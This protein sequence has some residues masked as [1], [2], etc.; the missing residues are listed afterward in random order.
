MRQQVC[1][2]GVDPV[3]RVRRFPETRRTKHR[4]RGIARDHLL[5]QQIDLA[6]RIPPPPMKPIGVGSLK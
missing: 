1:T 6:V 5:R 2:T 3:R 4:L